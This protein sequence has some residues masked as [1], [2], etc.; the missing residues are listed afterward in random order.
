M[1]LWRRFVR[2]LAREEL[3]QARA[4]LRELVD[5]SLRP[6]GTPTELREAI[7]DV[8]RRSVPAAV[9]G[10]VEHRSVA[11]LGPGNLRVVIEQAAFPRRAA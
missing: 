3:A 8:C 10:S 11:D 4:R 6:L 5:H 1:S 9:T 2:W 7:S